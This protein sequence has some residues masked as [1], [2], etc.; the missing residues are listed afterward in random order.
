MKIIYAK[1]LKILKRAN[2][3]KLV[4][5]YK[6]HGKK[7]LVER[8]KRIINNSISGE[9]YYLT[10]STTLMQSSVAEE[11]RTYIKHFI[12]SEIERNKSVSFFPQFYT[13]IISQGKRDLSPYWFWNFRIFSM[14]W[15]LNLKKYVNVKG[16]VCRQN[17]QCR[18]MLRLTL[19]IVQLHHQGLW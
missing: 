18:C 1:T 10:C 12:N 7:F 8:T 14:S 6:Y 5:F 2:E 17:P 9:Y 11:M 19:C 3:S 16:C 4:S 15:K 13:Q